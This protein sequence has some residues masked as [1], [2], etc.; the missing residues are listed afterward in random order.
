MW[1]HI[2]ENEYIDQEEEEEGGGLI[3]KVEVSGS[4]SDSKP[5]LASLSS[6]SRRPHL[7]LQCWRSKCFT[8]TQPT[9]SQD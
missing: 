3:L 2:W 8:Y 7:F 4:G 5:L 9:I 6:N 1:K